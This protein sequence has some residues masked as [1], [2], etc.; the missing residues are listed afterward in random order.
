MLKKSTV[1]KARLLIC[2]T[3]GHIVMP[4]IAIWFA[5]S[6]WVTGIAHILMISQVVNIIIQVLFTVIW[7]GTI[8]IWHKYWDKIICKSSKKSQVISEHEDLTKILSK[9]EDL[10]AKFDTLFS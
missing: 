9:H 8:F 7:F 3:M 2:H 10:S 6:Y 5:I 1:F 4:S